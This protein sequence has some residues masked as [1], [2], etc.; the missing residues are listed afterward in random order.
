MTTAAPWHYKRDQ[1]GMG[2]WPYRGKVAVAGMGNA[3]IVRR[4]DMKTLSTSLGACAIT[5]G[6]RALEDAG[7]KPEDIDGVMTSEDTILRYPTYWRERGLPYFAPPYHGEAGLSTVPGEWLAEQMG[8]KN[9]KYAETKGRPL[10]W[11]LL[12]KAAQAVGEG[13]CKT[14]LVWYSTGNLE[15]RYAQG[16]TN[17]EDTVT[18]EAQWSSPWGYQSGAMMNSIISFNQYCRKY[19]KNHDM[20]APLAVNLRRNGLMTPASFYTNHENYQLTIKDYL[21]ARVIMQPLVINDADRPVHTSAAFVFTT[22]ERAKDMKQKPVYVL[23]HAA[24]TE[25]HRSGMSTY[26]ER[27]DACDAVAR[28]LWESTG[29]EPKDVDL[30]NPYDGYL[31]FVHEQLEAFQWHGVK[32]GEALDFY[33]QDMRV[34][35]KDPFM[36]SSGN[37]GFG[38]ARTP[39]FT[40]S[41][42]QLRG[43]VGQT[44]GYAPMPNKRKV[45]VKCD[46][47]AV[48]AF[49]G[50]WIMFSKYPS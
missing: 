12:N 38:R 18:D 34:E 26:Q 35:G 36:S 9:V 39:H 24:H 46:T 43:T 25:G 11:E 30:F 28:K 33:Q 15:G 45:T 49:G 21:D 23:G 13:R 42:E 40:D 22:A 50:D 3:P 31:V 48:G 27:S 20:L 29:L 44:I 17:A 19:G 2:V 1:F 5:A 41:I 8:L 10:V 37:N 16:G 7:L 4:W 47:A 14:L 6:E 32:K